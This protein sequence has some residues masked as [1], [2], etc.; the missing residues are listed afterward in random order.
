MRIVAGD[1][2]G[3]HSRLG[4]VEATGDTSRLVEE[5]IFPSSDYPGLEPIVADFL[6]GTGGGCQRACFAIAGPVAGRRMHTTNLPWQVDADAI[7]AATGIATVILMNDLEAVGWG[8]GEL[9]P[10]DFLVL[11]DGEPEATGNGVVIAAGTG[12]GVAALI[13]DGARFRPIPSEG[14]HADF[15]PAD[16]LQAELLGFLA[17]RYGHVS[18]ERVLSGPG[19]VNLFEFFLSRAGVEVPA[20][21]E[22]A[23]GG[24]RAAAVVEAAASRDSDAALAAVELFVRLYG[25]AAGNAA[26]TFLARGGVFLGGGIAPK[27]ADWL[28]RPAFRTSFAAKG[29]MSGL[30]EKMPVKVI[31]NDSVALLGA[32]RRATLVRDNSG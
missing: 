2:G 23:E 19:L 18:W 30:L 12:L 31:L 11:N 21:F 8:I 28:R 6:S 24:D 9:S 1:I 26:L 25:A 20:W 15:A 29:R 4:L 5:R 14:G 22:A 10:P 16:E 3:T 7:E 13:W 32:A 17:R 27:I